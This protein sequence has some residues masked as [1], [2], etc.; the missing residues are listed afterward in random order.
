MRTIYRRPILMSLSQRNLTLVFCLLSAGT[1]FPQSPLPNGQVIDRVSAQSDSSQTYALYLPSNYTAEKKWPIIYVFEPDARGPLPVG[2]MKKWAERYGYIVVSSNV[3]RNGPVRIS[4]DAAAEMWRDTHLRFS[5]DDRRAYASGFSGGARVSVDVALNC[6]TCISDVVLF[7]AGFPSTIP[8]SSDAHFGVFAATGD[9]D[10]NHAEIVQLAPKLERLKIPYHT[11]VFPGPH[12]WGPDITW[13]HAFAWLEMRAMREGA[14]PKDQAFLDAQYADALAEAHRVEAADLF[15]AWHLYDQAARDYSGLVDASVA[16]K[17]AAELKDSKAV[18][19]GHKR[20]QAEIELFDRVTSTTLD[21]IQALLDEP[22]ER[23][24][25]YRKLHNTYADIKR[26]IAETH[27]EQSLQALAL[28]RA[29]IQA[30][31]SLNEV[32]RQAMDRHDYLMA[33]YFYDLITDF[34]KA[35][36]YAYYQRARIYCIARENKKAIAAL[37]RAVAQGFKDANSLR[38]TTEFASLQSD[39]NFTALLKRIQPGRE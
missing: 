2:L 19:D 16:E 29:L 3:S 31:V 4:L 33:G 39:P 21:G 34:A 38:T 24:E 26:Q 12:D 20:Q 11:E 5:I 15:T 1:V 6:K 18:R 14:K 23:A 17:R 30:F 22:S 28:R 27:D 7:G 32:A 9:L 8:P 13:Q 10:F 25:N 36:P 35:A 37:E